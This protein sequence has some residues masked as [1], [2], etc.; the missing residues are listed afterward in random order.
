MRDPLVAALWIEEHIDLADLSR[1][2]FDKF[3]PAAAPAQLLAL[4]P[5]ELIALFARDRDED[6]GPADPLAELAQMNRR[7]ATK[8]L[9]PAVPSWL[10]P[11][12]P[13]AAP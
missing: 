5:F 9:E 1:K 7:R 2:L 13:R 12:V 4:T 3:G 8:G 10:M 11:K 6:D